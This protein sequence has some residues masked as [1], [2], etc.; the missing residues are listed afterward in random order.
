M[1][2]VQ[3]APW[4]HPHLGGVESHVR[5]LGAELARR[6]HDV[7]VLTT[8]HDAALPATEEVD[9]VR[10]HR[11]KPLGVWLQTPI[12]PATKR[13]L[14]GLRA[15]VV[16]AHSPP[17]LSAYYAA[18]SAGRERLPFVITYHCDIELRV[19]MGGLLEAIY[20]RTLGAST[21]RR[22]D[23]VIM[24]THSYAAT[25]RTVW[26]YDPSVIPN[27]VDLDRFHPNGRAERVRA[28]HAIA[29]GEAIVLA[30]GRIVPHKGLEHFVEAARGV[31][32]ARFVIAGGGPHLAALRRLATALG[33]EDRVVL[34]GRVPN[35]ELPD[36]YAAC[37][38]FVL[39]SV[40]RL[41]A[42]GIVALEAMA[43]GK[44]VVVSDIPG[45][46]EVIADGSEGLLADAVNPEALAE[47][48]RA[49]LA[50]DRVRREMGDRARRAV[51]ERFSLP[52][53]VDA[54]E[55]VYRD[56]IARRPGAG[57]AT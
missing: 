40:S 30:V 32:G 46:R 48:I 42:F 38:V 1:R 35:E 57:V 45:V 44:P 17:P 34:A 6:G 12:V 20:R 3:V 50:N 7:T 39:P 27:F 8:R 49:L 41:E 56:A 54:I 25:S 4:F 9:G 13:A 16:H 55:A 26:R 10:V 33:V 43:S 19:P 37:D 31:D 36:Y 51:E 22:A 52:K 2:I 47:K 29:A 14:S 23:R 18:K 21:I 15:D 28:K 53:V 5:A 24:T 11:L